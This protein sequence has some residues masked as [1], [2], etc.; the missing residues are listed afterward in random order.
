MAPAASILASRKR[1]GTETGNLPSPCLRA[2]SQHAAD[3]D[4]RTKSRSTNR[5]DVF[6]SRRLV[7]NHQSATCVIRAAA[8]RA[9]PDDFGPLP[10]RSPGVNAAST[11]AASFFSLPEPAQMAPVGKSVPAR[12]MGS[13][14]LAMITSLPSRALLHEPR[15]LA[16][17]LQ[18]VDRFM[19]TSTVSVAPIMPDL[20]KSQLPSLGPVAVEREFHVP[21]QPAIHAGRGEPHQHHLRTRQRQIAGRAARQADG[22]ARRGDAALQRKVGVG[23]PPH[24]G[25]RRVFTF[26][27]DLEQEQAVAGPV[28][29]RRQ[30]DRSR[31]SRTENIESR[32]APREAASRPSHTSK[33]HLQCDAGVDSI[34]R[35]AP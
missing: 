32:P 18:H 23:Q 20:A 11:A 24:R 5:Y 31:Q 14:L 17:G 33:V 3:G 15:E 9:V 35:L 34:G 2:T 30:L 8:S 22:G 27:H 1:R 6:D 12:T 21:R 13:P 25:R 28:Q 16:L 19:T 29:M 26:R 10:R 4:R 7:V